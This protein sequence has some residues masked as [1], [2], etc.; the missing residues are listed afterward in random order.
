MD[1]TTAQELVKEALSRSTADQAEALLSWEQS[2]VTRFSNSQ[3]HQN[4][5]EVD[6]GLSVRAIVDKRTGSASTNMLD[7]R[8]IEETAGEALAAA[9]LAPPDPAFVSLP[10]SAPQSST[11]R[12]VDATAEATP[13]QRADIVAKIFAAADANGLRAAGSLGTTA[14]TLAVA[15]SLGTLSAGRLTE[16]ALN[17]VVIGEDSSGYAQFYGRDISGLDADQLARRAVDKALASRA[18]TDLAPGAYPVVLEPPAVADMIGFLAY[19]GLGAQSVQERRS[20]MCD[21]FGQRLAAECVTL[22]DD[23]GDPRTVGLPFDYEGVPKQKVV[24]LDK[25]VANAVVYDSYAAAKEGRQSTGHGLPAPNVHGALPTNLFMGTGSGTTDELIAGMERGLLV[26]RFHYTNVEEPMRAVLTGMTRDG[27]FWVENGRIMHAVKN[28][29]F[30]QSVLDALAAVEAVSA[31][32]ELVEG[33]L[34]PCYA[35]A[36]RVGAFN[37]TSA[38]E[39]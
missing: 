19:L 30:T 9:R 23:G 37:F 16:V 21:R 31:D 34:G 26:T 18:P 1:L 29:R 15:N 6:A 3:I 4:M 7:S 11:D 2:A 36:L 38:T 25:G 8:A 5:A 27:T 24:F 22:W 14:T 33:F 10:Q 12:Y 32:A 35:P 28:L 39:F 13:E 20:F 17:V